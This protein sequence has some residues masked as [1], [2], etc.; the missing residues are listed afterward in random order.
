MIFTHSVFKLDCFISKHY[1]YC[2]T[3]TVKLKEDLL[4]KLLIGFNILATF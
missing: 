1:F 3:E 4:P 2:C